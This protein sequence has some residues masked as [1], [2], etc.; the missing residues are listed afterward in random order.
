ML[1]LILLSVI[2]Y[3]IYYRVLKPSSYWKN[4]GVASLETW[5]MLGSGFDFIFQR[6][7]FAD[8]SLDLY[9]QF[10]NERY[11]GV[12]Q[13]SKPV[14][15]IRDVELVK[16]ITVK[17]FDHFVDH[18]TMIPDE[19]EPFFSKTLLSLKGQRWRDMRATLSPSFTSSKMKFMFPLLSDCAEEFINHFTK[20]KEQVYGME[21]KD[22]FTRFTNDAI[23]TAAFGLKCNSIEDKTNEF[24]MMGKQIASPGKLRSAVIILYSG[25]PKLAKLLNIQF[26]PTSVTNFFYRIIKETINV[27][28]QTGL[29]RPD[30]IHLLMEA[31]KGKQELDDNS[32]V[33]TGFAAVEESKVHHVDHKRQIELSDEDITAQAL[34]FFLGGFETASTL[35]CFITYELALNSEVQEK[36][37]KEIDETLAECNGKLTYEALH[38]MKYM[39]MVVSETLRKWPPGF[40]LDRL[41]IQDYLIE[42]VSPKEKSLLVEKGTI[43]VIPVI[44]I[45]RDEKYFPA[46]K[47]FDPERFSDEN[48]HNIKPFSYMPFG[49]GPRNCIASRFALMENKTVIFYLLSK[50]DIIP[51][52]RTPVPLKLAPGTITFGPKEGFWLGLKRRNIT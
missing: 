33:D 16:K 32:T 2:F 5:T 31:R 49:S 48:K 40:R 4:R 9:N 35:M 44:G 47:K 15:Y 36:L 17:D 14:L 11:F 39:D 10:G 8:L 38:K 25:F 21:M 27:R 19:S 29:V 46:P 18:S 51:I 23:A 20:K 13:F 50:F 28:E 12:R 45:H 3:L 41:C 6:K 37:Q 7:S 1:W 42:P 52:S 34:I 24:Y 30:M 26:F 43:V 22:A